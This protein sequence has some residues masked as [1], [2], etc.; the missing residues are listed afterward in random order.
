M[1]RSPNIKARWG[2]ENWRSGD[3]IFQRGYIDPFEY[4]TENVPDHSELLRGWTRALWGVGEQLWDI[5]VNTSFQ[6]WNSWYGNA[7]EF[8]RRPFSP[9][10]PFPYPSSAHTAEEGNDR[11]GFYVIRSPTGTYYS[12]PFTG[13][14]FYAG[15]NLENSVFEGEYAQPFI[16]V[17]FL[18]HYVTVEMHIGLAPRSARFAWKPDIDVAIVAREPMSRLKGGASK[19]A[20]YR[21]NE[22]QAVATFTRTATSQVTQIA[23]AFSDEVVTDEFGR[24][25]IWI[26]A[27]TVLQFEINPGS[28]KTKDAYL[29]LVF[30][31]LFDG[32]E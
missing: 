21:G 29:A 28:S 4:T 19:V 13:L 20:V 6:Y 26:P 9:H 1:Q 24:E 32:L 15:W 16:R 25:K 5:S 8:H 7:V 11:I 18:R 14:Q 3:I 27:G 17:P 2:I 10:V 23:N 30:E 31:A 22:D 12:W